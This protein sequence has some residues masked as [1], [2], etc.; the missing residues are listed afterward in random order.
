MSVIFDPVSVATQ[1]GKKIIDSELDKWHREFV[2]ATSSLSNEQRDK[3]AIILSRLILTR[4]G[5]TGYQIILAC[6]LL[7]G[8]M[9]EGFGL[10]KYLLSLSLKDRPPTRSK[11]ANVGDKVVDSTYRL[12][13]KDGFQSMWR[14][15]FGGNTTLVSSDMSR[16]KLEKIAKDYGIQG[17]G[18]VNE[19]VTRINVSTS[20]EPLMVAI[21]KQ[22]NNHHVFRGLLIQKFDDDFGCEGL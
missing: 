9:V 8:D 13:T 4:P 6:L 17:S 11:Y 10:Y 14:E 19:L 15:M 16:K 12:V 18:S 7:T 2:K 3:I 5:Q 1:V 21:L 22:P 20:K